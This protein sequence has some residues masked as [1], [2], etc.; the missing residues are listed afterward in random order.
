MKIKLIIAKAF[1]YL[2]GMFQT[3]AKVNRA[4]DID[5]D[6]SVY[7]PIRADRYNDSLAH[8]LCRT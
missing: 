8:R 6:V 1:Y 2:G 4:I 5:L 7:R 3:G